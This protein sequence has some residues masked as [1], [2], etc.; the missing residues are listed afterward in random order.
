MSST[1]LYGT[2]DADVVVDG[3]RAVRELGDEDVL[4]RRA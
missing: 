3:R 2:G 1:Q 4:G